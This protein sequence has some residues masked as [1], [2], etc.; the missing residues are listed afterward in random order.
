MSLLLDSRHG[1][2]Q[3]RPMD[4]EA[5][6]NL[7]HAV[8]RHEA[9]LD[10]MA[11][12]AKEIAKLKADVLELAGVIELLLSNPPLFQGSHGVH[13]PIRQQALEAL[14]RVLPPKA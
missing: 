10:A 2:A 11:P 13:Y 4:D 5:F 6:R 3:N 8:G 7:E 9:D 12:Q 14:A 1:L